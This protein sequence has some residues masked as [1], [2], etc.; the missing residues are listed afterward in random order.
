MECLFTMPINEKARIARAKK[1]GKASG[2]NRRNKTKKRDKNIIL[3]YDYLMQNY[4]KKSDKF[5]AFE[6]ISSFNMPVNLALNE[7]P[8]TFL[9][10]RVGVSRQRIHQIVKKQ[11]S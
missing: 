6:Y 11:T 8:L 10:E 5:R 2:K 3:S 1:A 9:S 4:Q 7:S